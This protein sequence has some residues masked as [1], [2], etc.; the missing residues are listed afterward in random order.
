M[1]WAQ[2]PTPSQ[3]AIG[4]EKPY[5]FSGVTWGISVTCRAG[6]MIR[7]SWPTHMGLLVFFCFFKGTE[8]IW[9]W[10]LGYGKHMIKHIPWNSQRTNKNIEEVNKVPSFLITWVL[11]SSWNRLCAHLGALCSVFTPSLLGMA[12]WVK[13]TAKSHVFPNQCSVCIL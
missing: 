12:F 6:C 2:R 11:C 13:E 4:K 8:R 7:S 5:F 1:R 10:V 3:E 9:N